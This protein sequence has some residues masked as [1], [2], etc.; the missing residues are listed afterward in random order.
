MNKYIK[1]QGQVLIIYLTTMFVG[2]SSV[3]LGVVATGMA[4]KDIEKSVKT[5]V[6]DQSRQQQSL[7][8]LEQ[9]EDEGKALKKEYKKQRETLMDLVKNHEADK[10]AFDAVISEILT[11]DQQVSKRLLDIQYDLRQSITAEEWAKVFSGE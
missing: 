9:W 10:A 7:A 8:L 5:H 1:Q 6:Q 2:G 4:I 11:M 3:A